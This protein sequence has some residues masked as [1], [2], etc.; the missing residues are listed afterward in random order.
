MS[1][2]AREAARPAAA[3]AVGDLVMAVALREALPT[4]AEIGAAAR[5]SLP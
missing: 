2:A 5:G 4:P 1:A 3:A